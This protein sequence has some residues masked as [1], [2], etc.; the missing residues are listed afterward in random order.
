MMR[1]FLFTVCLALQTFILHCDRRVGYMTLQG[2]ALIAQKWGGS[3]WPG[4]A[5]YYAPAMM[6]LLLIATHVVETAIGPLSP[7][8]RNRRL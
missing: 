6:A 1:L 4:V 2:F 5:A 8:R 7:R 3:P